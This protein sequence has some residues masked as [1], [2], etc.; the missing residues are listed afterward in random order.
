MSQVDQGREEVE[1]M[2]YTDYIIGFVF[3]AIAGIIIGLGVYP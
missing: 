1:L 3:G 2:D